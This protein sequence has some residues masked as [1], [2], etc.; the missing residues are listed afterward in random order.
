MTGAGSRYLAQPTPSFWK[1]LR[2]L[3]DAR[4]TVAGLLL[5]YVPL[6]GRESAR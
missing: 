4:F 5:A 2:Y 6:L 1:S 3:S